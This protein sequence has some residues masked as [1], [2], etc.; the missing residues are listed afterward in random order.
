MLILL[1]I[2]LLAIF[3]TSILDI[4][5]GSY[6]NNISPR[7]L[8]FLWLISNILD[9]HSTILCISTQKGREANPFAALFVKFLGVK[10]GLISF[11]VILLVIITPSLF[12]APRI[13]FLTWTIIIFGVALHNYRL[14]GKFNRMKDGQ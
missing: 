8:L 3:I 10:T 4:L 11:K 2:L 5:F 14:Y 7:L 13:M 6:I 9:V 1:V 12:Y